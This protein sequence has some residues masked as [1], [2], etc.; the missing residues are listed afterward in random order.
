[1]EIMKNHEYYIDEFKTLKIFI[2]KLFNEIKNKKIEYIYT[3]GGT[4]GGVV[5]E[6]SAYD[7]SDY[8]YVV[9]D[10]DSV[11]KFQYNFFSMMYITYTDLDSLRE[12]EKMNLSDD[13]E[14]LLCKLNLEYDKSKI[15]DYEIE[16]FSDEYIIEPSSDMTRPE[17]GDYFKEIIFHLDNDKKLCICAQNAEFDGYCDVWVEN[18]SLKGIFNGQSHT[19]W[20]KD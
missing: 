11:I 12:E 1:M 10:D 7:A 19:V 16:Q 20:W 5:K 4:T 8:V 15:V 9:F 18:N 14:V 3:L 17:G 2:E 13:R 6:Y